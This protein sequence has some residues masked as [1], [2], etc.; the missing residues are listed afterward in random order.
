MKKIIA[1]ILSL[2]MILTLVTGCEKQEKKVTLTMNMGTGKVIEPFLK[3][4]KEKFPNINFEIYFYSG[5]ATT[6]FLRSTYENHDVSDIAFYT[7]K[8]DNNLAKENLINL[9]RYPFLNNIDMGMLNQL[10]VDGYIYQIPGP[11]NVRSLVYNKTLFE[12]YDWKAPESFDD[13]EALVRQI[14]KDAPE[15]IPIL[16]SLGGV[17]YPFTIVTLF[18]QAG[19]LSTPLGSQWE[20]EYLAGDVSIQQ[21][22]E[23]GLEM[24]SRLIDAGAFPNAQEWIGKWDDA[25][26]DDYFSNGKAAMFLAWGNQKHLVNVMEN[27]DYDYELLPIYSL[28]GHT[29]TIGVLASFYFG[30]NKQ[31]EAKGNEDKLEAALKVMEWIASDEG[32]MLLT[33]NAADIPS[34]KNSD[35]ESVSPKYRDLW[36]ATETV[37][38]APMLYGGYEDILMDA[39]NIIQEHMISGNSEGMTEEFIKRSDELHKEAL[40]TNTEKDVVAYGEFAEKFDRDALPQFIANVINNAHCGDFALITRSYV[41]NGISNKQGISG[42]MYPG[43]VGDIGIYIMMPSPQDNQIVVLS[44]TGSDIKKLLQEGKSISD[45]NGNTNTYDY[46]WS[47]IDVEMKDDTILS[48]KL[49]GTELDDTKTYQVAFYNNDYPEAIAQAGNP[50]DTGI[51]FKNLLIDYLKKQ[52]GPISAPEVKRSSK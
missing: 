45:T 36:N 16:I 51:T 28:D 50:Q 22:F 19:F 42:W 52:D 24:T 6:D 18:S 9:T 43:P 48:A 25:I 37:Y 34:T 46:Y 27:S 40:L 41:E 47:G 10:D 5:A 7:Q 23:E 17:A 3:A 31:L 30:L 26:I 38:K 32:Q 1:L 15:M 20:R 44:L 21:G 35:L 49:N 12:Q 14:R 11:V 13:L 29:T 33:E 2:M 8:L 4:M 39:G